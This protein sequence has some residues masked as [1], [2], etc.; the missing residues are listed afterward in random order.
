MGRMASVVRVVVVAALVVTSGCWW[1]TGFGAQRQGFNDLETQVTTD[2]VGDLVA[3]WTATV[4]G[5]PGEAVVD[6]GRVFVPAARAL[7]AFALGDGAEQWSGC[8]PGGPAVVDG[9]LR[10]AVGGATGCRMVSIDPATGASTDLGRLGPE[11]PEWPGGGC[12]PGDV[13]AVGTRLVAPWSVSVG[14]V[15]GGP[16]SPCTRI[17]SWWFVGSGVSLL[18]ATTGAGWERDESRGTCVFASP[19]PPTPGFGP[20]SSDGTS[21][22]SP[23][24]RTLQALPLDCTAAG[25]PASWSVDVGP[26]VGSTA[27]IVGPAVVLA[28]GDIAL[29]T[30]DGH[31]V[32]VDGATHQVAWTAA[33]GAPL[34]QPLA[35]TPATVF[36]TGTDGTVAAL[37][38]GGCGTTTCA[39]TWTATLAGPPSARPSIGGDVLYVGSSDGTLTALP[40]EGCGA[41]TCAPLWTGATPARITGAPA[42]SAGTVVVG[43]AD[44]TV[45]AF[46]LP[47]P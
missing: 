27:T 45:T 23:R 42:I 30:S 15:P 16:P 25:C 28:G 24:G 8:C 12:G 44:G 14:P 34:D 2:V 1:Q 31:V 5:T 11:L 43:S 10:V 37:P 32:V 3:R 46:G 13:L 33:L 35:A 17:E 7:T 9:R 40:A 4:D 22:L 47:S 26:A 18:D 29:G 19:P 41:A 20:L 39:P 36:A 38:A 6:G 21:V